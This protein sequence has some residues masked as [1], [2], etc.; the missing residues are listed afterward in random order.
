MAGLRHAGGLHPEHPRLRELVSSLNEKSYDFAALW[1]SQTVYGKTQDATEL[2]HPD[3]GPLALVSSHLTSAPRPANSLVIYQPEPDSPSAQALTLSAR[4]VLADDNQLVSFGVGDL[5]T[6]LRFVQ[7]PPTG[8]DDR[9]EASL[10]EVGRHSELE[11]DAIALPAPLRIR[12]VDL[13]KHQFRVQP[14][15][16]VNIADPRPVGRGCIRVRRPRMRE[17]RRRR[18]RRGTAER[19]AAA[20]NRLWPRVRGQRPGRFRRGR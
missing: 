19:S 13:L 6:I 17:P 14:P 20:L 1:S 8:C 12:S 7:Q 5:P 18:Q 4:S 9:G 15:R 16:I 2:N 3:V 10:R 11:M